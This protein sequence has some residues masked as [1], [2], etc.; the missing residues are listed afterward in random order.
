MP[1]YD[2]V[3][4]AHEGG[5]T[6]LEDADHA[7]VLLKSFE[8]NRLYS[9]D[10]AQR[11]REGVL[12][13]STNDREFSMSWAAT[14]VRG[15]PERTLEVKN[16]KKFEGQLLYAGPA[17]V[18]EEIKVGGTAKEI[19][20]SLLPFSATVIESDEGARGAAREFGRIFSLLS[21]GASI[22][23][24]YGSAV[25]AG[26]GLIGAL[27]ELVR[28]QI[29][30]DLELA[31]RG[32][33]AKPPEV[34]DP[35]ARQLVTGT[36]TIS[37]GKAD[38]DLS[39]A[40]VKIDIEVLRLKP[41]PSTA[42]L[43]VEIA[44]EK[45]VVTAPK[46][47]KRPGRIAIE[48]A[49]GSGDDSL[50]ISETFDVSHTKGKFDTIVGFLNRPVYRGLMSAGL[51]FTASIAAVSKEFSDDEKKAMKT[52]IEKLGG[53]AGELTKEAKEQKRI[54]DAQ[55]VAE[56]V[57]S[58]LMEFDPK[59]VSIG[60]VAG[61]FVTGAMVD[62]VPKDDKGPLFVIDPDLVDEWQLREVTLSPGDDKDADDERKATIHFIV[63]VLE[64]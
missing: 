32:A 62:D 3:H 2:K 12:L 52:L 59:K 23:P 31:Y 51:A 11:D 17:H 15:D 27:A 55:K 63:R 42:P 40:G 47:V 60:K 18:T 29:D 19:D 46:L 64:T 26:F 22:V 14:K 1:A 8:V 54:K 24:A 53:F 28:A 10:F 4:L 35:A 9:D 37:G 13:F 48:I 7:I 25:S 36:Y 21:A 61:L 43:Y 41:R 38:D 16:S 33:L 20:W 6:T 5:G 34:N 45:I 50:P 58:Y 57:R 30:D 44:V 49:V 39:S 56:S